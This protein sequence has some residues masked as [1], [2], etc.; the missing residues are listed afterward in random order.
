M[1]TETADTIVGIL[2]A[3]TKA[4]IEAAKG[5]P[6]PDAATLKANIKAA[7]AAHATDDGWLD[8]AIAAAQKKYDQP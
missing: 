8:A 3:I 4:I 1:N 7:L 5:E 2:T 6:A